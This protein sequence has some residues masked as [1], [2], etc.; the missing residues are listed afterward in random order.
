MSGRFPGA[1]SVERFW[2]N[3]ASGVESIAFFSDEEL[4]ASGVEPALLADPAY[5]RAR[6]IVEGAEL[7]DAAFFGF[8]PREAEVL[9][10]QHRMF[11]ECAWEAL[12]NAGHDPRRFPGPVGVFAGAGMNTYLLSNLQHNP[13]VLDA[14]G[15]YQAMLGSG[16]DFLAT[17][18]SYK[19]GLRGPSLTVQTACSTSLVAVHLAVQSL[20]NGECDMALAGGVRLLVPRKA[21]HLYTPGGIFSQDGHCRPF[22]ASA[23][24]T[25]EGEGAGVVVLRRL[26]DAL[27]D[28]DRV[29]AVILGSAINNDGAAKVGYTAPSA[30]GQAEVVALAQAL[31]GVEPDTIGYVEAHGTGTPLGDPIEVSALAQVFAAEDTEDNRGFCALGSVKSNI[32]H[33]D[34]AAG[35]ASLIK[36]TLALERG[37][38]PPSLHFERPNPQIDLETGPFHVP[39]RLD[40]WR[41]PGPRRAG[42]SSFGIGGTNAHVVME[43]AQEQP[44]TDPAQG[45]QLLVLSARTPSALE[46]LTSGLAEHLRLHPGL[47]LA[48]VAWTLQ[49]GRAA[50]DHRRMVVAE[51]AEDAAGVLASLDPKRVLTRVREAGERPVVFLFPGQGSQHPGMAAELYR[52]EPVFREQL[53]LAA[54]VLR[55]YLGLDLRQAIHPA[56]D[57]ER[58]R[59]TALAQPALFAVEHAL[60]RLWMSWGVRPEAML[61]HSVGEYVAACLAGVFEPEEALRLVAERGRLMQEMPAGAMLAVSLPEAEVRPL[62]GG[63]ALAAVNGPALCVV[64]GDFAEIDDLAARLEARGVQVRRL[65]T[66]HAFHSAAMDPILGRFE[67]AFA[68][69]ELKAPEIPFVSNR[70]GAWIRPEEATDPRY[71]ARHLRETVRF[72]AGL[73]LLF[74]KRS[75]ALLE[76]GPG[77]ALTSL[78]R[79]HPG[80]SGAQAALP[81][82]PAAGDATSELPDDT[83]A[84][85]RT[86]GQLWLSGVEID[87]PAFHS[88]EVRRRVSLPTYPFERE[89]FWVEPLPGAARARRRSSAA[90]VAGWLW[91][92]LW[93]QELPPGGPAL[94]DGADEGPW[95][96]FSGESFGERLA[97]RLRERGRTAAL[98]R[99]GEDFQETDALDFTMRPGEAADYAALLDRLAEKGAV[100]A[101]IVHLWSAGPGERDEQERG[102]FSLMHLVRALGD[103]RQDAKP[104]PLH[105]GIVTTGVQRIAGEELRPERATVLGPAATIPQEYPGITCQAVDVTLPPAGSRRE[106]L[107][108]DLLLAELAAAPDDPVVAFRGTDR[109]LRSWEP[110]D[111]QGGGPLPLRQGGTYLITGGLGGVGLELA[112]LLARE[113]R[114]RL[115]LVGRGGIEERPERAA[116]LRELERAGA[117]VLV[118]AADVTDEA[119][120]GRALEQAR[121]RFGPI[122]GAIHAAGLAGGGLMQWRSLDEAA[123]VLAPKVRGTLVLERLLAADTADEPDFLVLC[124]SLNALLGG[125]G[126]AD[127]AAANAFLDAFAQSRSGDLPVVSIDWDAWRGVGM[128]AKPGAPAEPELS[129][130][131]PFSHPLLTGHAAGNG[132]GA[133]VFV[134]HLRPGES[135]ILDDHRLGGHPVVPGTAYLEMAGAAFRGLREAGGAMELSDVVFVTPMRV[136][137]G[138]TREVRT[139][140]QPNGNPSESAR[141]FVVRSRDGEGWQDHAVG[142]ITAV[143]SDEPARLDLDTVLGSW[144]EEVLGEDYREG[145]KQAGLGPRWEV[146]KKVYRQDGEVVG[147]LELAPELAADLESF[148][149]HPALLDVATSFAEVYVPRG[150]GYYLPLSYK[151]MRVL[152]P[153]TRRLYS[154][155]RLRPQGLRPGETLSFDVGIL[156]ESGVERI[157]VEEF[158]LK[159]VD[160][161]GTLRARAQ[162]AANALNIP[163]VPE[164]DEGMEPERAAEAFLRILAGARLP[165]VAVS[166]RPLPE[167]LERARSLSAAR[168]AESLKPRG[169]GGGGGDGDGGGH[170]RPE[171]ETPY[172][173]PRSASEERL[174][175]IWRDVLGIDRVGVFDDFFELGGHSLLG[176]QLISRVREELGAEIPLGRL[177]E[178]STVADFAA[179]VE[180]QL[181][182]SGAAARDEIPFLSRDGDL[183]LS[184]SQERIWFLD[185]LDPGNAFYNV[186]QAVRLDGRLDAAALAESLGEIVRRHEVLRTAFV[187][188]GGRPVQRVLP[189]LELPLP[190]ADLA[191]LPEEAREAEA[192]RL[193]VLTS[194]RSFDLARPP[195]LAV[196][197]VRLAPERHVLALALHHIVSDGWS[198]GVLLSELAALYGARAAGAASPLVPLPVQY[199]DFAA[200][201]R[202]S[203]ERGGIGDQLAYWRRQLGGP[204]PVL[205]LPTDRPR[206]AFQTFRG[207]AEIRTLPAGLVS[208]LKAL[209]HREGA[210]PFMGLLSV[211]ALL[212]QRWSGQDDLLVGSPIAGRNRREV[213][214]LIGMFLN[215]LVLRVDLSG[216]PTFRGLL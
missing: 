97:A 163:E 168:L 14:V 109:W 200:W 186:T 196:Q 99:I 66:S 20:L 214:G 67:A 30:E 175:A 81:S 110:L 74:A 86:A 27:A 165:Q 208:S 108:I 11:L 133:E 111:L 156:D 102:F 51:G 33:L 8:N 127:Y 121:E 182:G 65:H 154:H 137:D 216:T 118:L 17:R 42:V 26:A 184:F 180:E 114:A 3:L 181:G 194:R 170:A 117:E 177:F 45:R 187:E 15:S 39:T 124:S 32:G 166:V 52:T 126:Q 190:V 145:L 69:L 90:G 71:W 34:A 192:E 53:D 19:L 61:G 150:E 75:A 2:E 77:R 115:V 63:L 13:G 178:A 25:V 143:P 83:A 16:G 140:L 6:G 50:F 119:S 98:V 202:E 22:D 68:G 146:L 1:P 48:D 160:V 95:L 211:F 123:A 116:R 5:V 164:P 138:E 167:E 35:V 103:R 113:A 201:Q 57:P 159:R 29:R 94:A 203:L 37:L 96:V 122:H 199:A 195:L 212:L 79:Q 72:S 152:G 174:A 43:Q 135:W 92:P 128:A 54:E 136:G 101:R 31:A 207:V 129:E 41:V 172:V 84:L 176:T 134:G 142:A 162:K 24:G 64:A 148:Q 9:D 210:T 82:L 188:A 153:L 193:A 106:R 158:T 149:L 76:V 179:A 204:L 80:R 151:R 205:E 185:R 112:G 189:G 60:A 78:A 70:T 141:R 4:L 55:P 23:V 56:A 144:P 209:C 139:I 36:A 132:D 49:A 130:V 105:L 157:R 10:P 155:A 85:L 28:G 21:G 198:I 44:A 93:R 89:R 18:V 183:E 58:L 62:L 213:E 191:A 47:D 12:E 100:P 91:A 125:P 215:T 173:A 46:E 87:W 107:L 40:S 161:A 7:F 206:P 147:L 131:R 38:I 120:M 104:A 59:Q 169:V 88:G 171:L 73:E 197:L